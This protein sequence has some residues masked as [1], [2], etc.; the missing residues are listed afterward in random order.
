M[1]DWLPEDYEKLRRLTAEGLTAGEISARMPGRTRN[2]VVGQWHRSGLKGGGRTQRSRKVKS[3]EEQPPAPPAP[4][5]HYPKP[6]FATVTGMLPRRNV[7]PAI[8]TMSSGSEPAPL[9]VP[10]IDL[11]PRMCKWPVNDGDPFLFCGHAT[12][13]GQSYCDYHYKISVRCRPAPKLRKGA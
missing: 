10:L 9:M 11:E 7:A 2:A 3:P 5:I 6:N 13:T 1:A 12:Q 4:K 8:P